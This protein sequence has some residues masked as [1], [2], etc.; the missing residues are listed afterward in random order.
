M[1]SRNRSI[2]LKC[3]ILKQSPSNPPRLNFLGN[4]APSFSD[5]VFLPQVYFQKKTLW[6]S[7]GGTIPSSWSKVQ[8]S[9]HISGEGG[10]I[11]RRLTS[12]ASLCRERGRLRIAQVGGIRY[13]FWGRTGQ[14]AI[15]LTPS[16]VT[17]L[18]CPEVPI[19][20][21]DWSAWYASLLLHAGFYKLLKDKSLP[22]CTK[23]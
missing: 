11:A 2:C 18:L 1:P 13:R 6:F 12:Q 10:P 5:F 8:W 3:W 19:Y 9:V 16:Y 15:P 20:L 14:K 17:S 4:N 21:S 23:K 7:K 22:C